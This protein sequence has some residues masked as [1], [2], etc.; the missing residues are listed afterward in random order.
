LIDGVNLSL[1][2]VNTLLTWFLA[3]GSSDSDNLLL[4]ACF[5][6]TALFNGFSIRMNKRLG[7]PTTVDSICLGI[8]VGLTVTRL[9]YTTV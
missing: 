6:I 5:A 8:Y 9:Y 4:A 1:T 7:L 3:S 2:L